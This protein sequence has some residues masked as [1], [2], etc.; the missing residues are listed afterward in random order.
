MDSRAIK[1]IVADDH[2]EMLKVVSAYLNPHFQVLAC[3]PDGESLIR[4]A[5]ELKPDVI[6]SD[7]D[8]PGYDGLEVMLD[9]KNRRVEIPI[10][11]MGNWTND[12]LDFLELGAA[13]YVHKYDIHADIV[14][15]VLTAAGGGKFISRSILPDDSGR[16]PRR[17]SA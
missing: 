2:R 11:L 6:I 4:F 17:A 15:A 14:E 16:G 1:V 7:L 13:A 9:L 10:V 8:L 3:V 12:V 5:I